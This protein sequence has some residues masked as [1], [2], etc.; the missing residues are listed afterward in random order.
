MEVVNYGRLSI[1]LEAIKGLT[2]T[3][4]KE[5]FPKIKERLLKGAWDLANPK[6]EKKKK[7]TKEAE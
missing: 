5:A 1:R 2:W 3:E 6:T 4:C 7:E